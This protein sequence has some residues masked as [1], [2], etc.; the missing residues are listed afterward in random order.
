MLSFHGDQKVKDKYIARLKAHEAADEITK[1]V[2]WE[3]GKGCAVGCTI[4]GDDH[5]AYEDELGIPMLLARL[6][7]GIFEGLPNDVAKEFPLRFLNAVPVGVD[8]ADVFPKF[9]LWLLIDETHGVY[10]YGYE[11]GKIAIQAVAD[12]YK[13]KIAGE[14][15]NI[16]EW[17]L[18]RKNAAAAYAADAAAYAADAAAYAADAAAYA[19]AYAAAYAAAAAAAVAA[20][21]AAAD[22]YDAA[23]QKHRIAQANKL[24]E[25]I[26][27]CK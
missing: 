25:L 27:Q 22:A 23:R 10:Q 26:E 11:K 18:A 13:R 6:E 24:I 14:D 9:M 20:A 19:S 15:I 2:Y 3:D 17:L 12:L 21:Y 5:S 1:G 7:D 8:L 16:D 4:H